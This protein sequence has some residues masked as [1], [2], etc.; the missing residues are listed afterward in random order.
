[1]QHHRESRLISV[2]LVHVVTVLKGAVVVFLYRDGRRS[3]VKK[4]LVLLVGACVL[5]LSACGGGAHKSSAL[6][7]ATTTS[8]LSAASQSSTSSAPT[9]TTTTVPTVTQAS[10]TGQLLLDSTTTE[11][12]C[13]ASLNNSQ[14][15]GLPSPTTSTT[16]GNGPSV[17]F[18]NQQ[19]ATPGQS[20]SIS[21][22]GL[23]VFTCSPQSGDEFILG[24][25]M[26]TREIAYKIDVAS[27]KSFAVGTDHVFLL[28]QNNTP[29]S[30]LNSGTTS[31]SITAKNLT[32]GSTSW[33]E[34]IPQKG[35]Y[36]SGYVDDTLAVT[37]NPAGVAGVAEDAVVSFEG[38]TAFNSQTGQ[39]LW[40][41]GN[42]YDTQASGSYTGLGIVEVGDYR[43]EW[44]EGLTG[45]N[46][47]TGT[48]VWAFPYPSSCQG[49]FYNSSWGDQ[50]AG[51]VEWLFSDNCYLA[52]NF[53]TGQT[54]ATGAI[55]S[56]WTGDNA[57]YIATPTEALVADGTHLSLYKLSN[58]S[59]PVWSIAG[60][61]V[62]PLA[63]GSSRVLVQGATQPL[64]LSA[65]NGSTIGS[66]SNATPSA[67]LV[68]N[69]LLV[70][71][72]TVLDMG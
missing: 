34:A 58:L 55:P 8:P 40:H 13:D 11:D 67:G 50:I 26:Y 35:S 4:R 72:D 6:G 56:S 17:Q 43:D 64:F 3:F 44:G 25:N 33:T 54:V 47:A 53:Q 19:T 57:T 60:N 52:Y 15:P 62:Q 28:T 1:M 5:L 63:I 24:F 22:S 21:G 36:Q 27:Y 7:S 48:Q 30:G 18:T 66:L 61:D 32:D 59:T 37:E 69:G 39:L 49:N 20:V 16:D 46:A 51:N 10:L 9:S 31:Y 29:A 14:P 2:G 65:A 70:E 71:G 68:T 23:A 12:A 42:Q 45:E 38:T 41:T